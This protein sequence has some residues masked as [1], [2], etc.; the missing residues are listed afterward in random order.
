MLDLDFHWIWDVSHTV[1]R[2]QGPRKKNPRFFLFLASSHVLNYFQN[3]WPMHQTGHH[4][5]H[6]HLNWFAENFKS[7]LIKSCIPCSKFYTKEYWLKLHP[8]DLC[9]F[10]S[11]G[12]YSFLPPVKTNNGILPA[13]QLFSYPQQPNKQFADL[14][15][16][17][18]L[19]NKIWV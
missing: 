10:A 1:S 7:S 14:L 11:S 15:Q 12:D 6:H 13:F 16:V 3:F 2:S 19:E 9:P 18:E 17:C 5:M 4:A 8:W